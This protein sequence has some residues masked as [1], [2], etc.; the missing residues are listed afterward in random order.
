[1]PYRRGVRVL[2]RALNF[3]IVCRALAMILFTAC[4]G[5]HIAAPSRGHITVTSGN[6]Q[7]GAPGQRLEQPI[8]VVVRDIN[9][10]PAAGVRVTWIADDGGS[11][12]P[13]QSSTDATGTASA[14]WIL[15]PAL[16][17]HRG[18][19]L[20][21]SYE[22]VQFTA[23]TPRDGELPFDVIQPLVLSTYDGS[24]QTVHPD[25][26][27]AGPE[28]TRSADYLF[29]TP[30]PNGNATFENPSV[31]DSPDLLRWTAPSG[32]TNPIA[33]PAEG[34]YS[35]PDGVFVPERNELWLYFRQV[36]SENII[37]LTR[38]ADGIH[39]SSPVIVAHAP[40]HEIIS[41]TIVRRSPTDW[42][43]W[44]VN[45]NVGCTGLN[46]TVELR[47]SSDGVTWS[48]P[49]TVALS[50]S[51]LYPWHIDVE[52]IPS[53]NEFWALY[54]TKTPGSCTTSAVYLGTSG[55]GVRWTTYPSPV[56]THGAIPEFQDVVYRS[57]L[58]YDEASDAVTI[59]YSGARYES[60]NY[61]W[62]SAVQRRLR[63]DLFATIA[64]TPS[65][66]AAQTPDRVVP[67]LRDFP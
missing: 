51:G 36:T 2:S 45:G 6:A 50:Q 47:R 52:W 4:R 41:P 24:G 58:S 25:Y 59:W 42:L 56:L 32:V 43:M 1:M 66:A 18:R 20:A 54:N 44:S 15:G 13:A 3:R 21:Q 62:R 29:I 65:R 19:A 28:W 12:A 22:P 17:I 46:T 63:A 39:W 7:R 53:R 60:G 61:I 11:I 31:Y 64:A 34:Y 9:G 5:D 35:D 57:T 30:Y 40:N 48:A 33:S 23:S 27:A 37:R 26:V 67:P 16:T 8:V 49:T 38:S 14:V 10:E 55:D